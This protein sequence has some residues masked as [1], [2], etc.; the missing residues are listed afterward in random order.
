MIERVTVSLPTDVRQAAQQLAESSGSSFSAVVN[1]ALSSWLRAKLVD[2][3][4]AEHQQT[5]GA[6]D[7]DELRRLAAETGV[8]YTAP[9]GRESAA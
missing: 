1:E 5:H 8:P 4:L 6:F 7:E 3:W 2:A 9:R